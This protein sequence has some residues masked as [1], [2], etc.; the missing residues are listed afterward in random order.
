VALA[1]QKS[2]M[3]PIVSQ[4]VA[5][6]KL[7][8]YNQ[9]VDAKRPL[10]GFRLKN[11]TSLYLMQGPITVFDDNA[12]AGDARIEDLAPEQERLLSYALDLKTEVEPESRLGTNEL[13]SVRIRRGTLVATRR[14]TEEKS[15]N[16][17]NRDQVKK[18]V[19]IEH[20][21]RPDWKLITPNEPKERTRNAYR[22]QVDVEPGKTASVAVQEEKQFNEE[23][24]LISANSNFGMYLKSKKLSSKVREAL[25]H[26]VAMR[27]KMSQTASER[28][29]HEQRINEITQEQSRIRGN[30]ERLSQT[31]EL[32]TRYVKK[33]D[34]QETDLETLR[35]QIETL[36]QT[37]NQQQQEI[38]DYLSNL[39][40]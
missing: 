37:E 17:R 22:F 14:A 2:A 5:G 13:V 3:L 36:H 31:S 20:P 29:Q 7:S 8:I 1:R 21:Y 10:N 9:S 34:Q 33:L 38:N 16:V 15:Y 26:V 6:D 18:T 4:T 25:E 11:S 23:I 28:S 24:Q 40:V 35:N 32:Y 30:M 39:D 27:N 12:Y 19:L